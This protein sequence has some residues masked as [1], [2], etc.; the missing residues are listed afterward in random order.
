MNKSPS[1]DSDAPPQHNA[2]GSYLVPPLFESVH[3]SVGDESVQS[4]GE[5]DKEKQLLRDQLS[6]LSHS[7]LLEYA[8][9]T[10]TAM[11]E[12]QRAASDLIST[13][14]LSPEM[15]DLYYARS[16]R[17]LLKS[18][19]EG[20]ESVDSLQHVECS[21]PSVASE[22]P[23]VNIVRWDGLHFSECDIQWAPS[24]W[25]V[26]VSA[27]GSRWGLAFNCHATVSAI[28]LRGRVQCSFSNDLTAMRIR[29][30]D[31]PLLNLDVDTSV[32]W[33]PVPLPVRESIARLIREKIEQ[34]L[35]GRL[36]NEDGMV[37]VL[38]R[39]PLQK[40]S[41]NDVYEATMQARRANSIHLRSKSLF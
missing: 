29:F 5:P 22:K 8:V 4:N 41:E 19:L 15:T 32:G 20:L 17:I 26:S 40:I 13:L 38:K 7:A 10:Q 3:D 37:I 33:G 39:K 6:L 14:A 9:K 12:W 25:W 36:C 30:I 23:F 1:R 11:A 28:S 31:K 35:D 24:S 21:M 34:F 18:A 2:D 27:D 16:L